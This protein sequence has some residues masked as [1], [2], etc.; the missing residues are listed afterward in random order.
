MNK[1]KRMT[2]FMEAPMHAFPRYS[3]ILLALAFSIPVAF[4]QDVEDFDIAVE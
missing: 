2:Y 4:A 1:I 3:A